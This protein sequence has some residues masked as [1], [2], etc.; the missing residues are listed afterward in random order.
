MDNLQILE[1]E[2]ATIAA[3]QSELTAQIAAQKAQA[4]TD[5]IATVR[6]LVAEHGITGAE[7]GIKAPAS[8]KPV[9]RKRG[10]APPKYRSPDGTGTWA[11]RGKRPGWFNAALAGGASAASMLIHPAA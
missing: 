2:A 4:R 5:A 3:R 1:Q 7:V 6:A 8:A 10:I 11:G 9:P